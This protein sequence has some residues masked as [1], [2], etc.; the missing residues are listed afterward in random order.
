MKTGSTQAHPY[1]RRGNGKYK[2]KYRVVRA[3]WGERP[4]R[5]IPFWGGKA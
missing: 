3:G 2:R 4:L 1:K 5:D